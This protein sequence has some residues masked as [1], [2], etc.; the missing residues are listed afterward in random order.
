MPKTI[1]CPNA[2]C[3]F[4]GAPKKKARGSII[5]GLVLCCF[6]L[7]PGLIYFMLR[8]GYT[9]LCPKCGFQIASDS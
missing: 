3:A 2:N 1:I 4:Q 5:V 6:F 9:Y 7:L 8:S